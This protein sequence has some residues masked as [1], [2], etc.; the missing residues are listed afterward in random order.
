MDL[1]G[2]VKAQSRGG[3]KYILVIVDDYSRFTWTMFLKSKYET[4]E[5]KD[6]DDLEGLLH[7]QRDEAN[8]HALKEVEISMVLILVNPR[9]MMQLTRLMRELL[10]NTFDS[11]NCRV[12]YITRNPKDTLVSMWHFTNKWKAVDQDGPWHI[13]EAIEKFCSGVFPGGPYYDHVMGFKNSS[14]EKPTNIFLITYEELIKDT[15]IHVKR[16]AEFLGFPL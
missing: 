6:D 16:L 4:A 8:I 11:S 14:L 5:H 13:E 2:Y 3:K 9:R 12:V 10:R 1:C 7:I 15:K